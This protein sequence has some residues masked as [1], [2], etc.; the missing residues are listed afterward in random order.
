MDAEP[1]RTELNLPSWQLQYI[2][3]RRCCRAW[4]L[5]FL[6]H[7]VVFCPVPSLFTQ[8]AKLRAEKILKND[9]IGRTEKKQTSHTKVRNRHC[10][11]NQFPQL[12]RQYISKKSHSSST[13]LR[14]H[15]PLSFQQPKDAFKP[16]Y[17]SV[18]LISGIDKTKCCQT[19]MYHRILILYKK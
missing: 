4:K 12:N 8:K 7:A 17:S 1:C 16:R 2:T 15:K 10:C 19:S 14:T 6:K 9:C 5:K 3:D 11:S 13:L 18:E